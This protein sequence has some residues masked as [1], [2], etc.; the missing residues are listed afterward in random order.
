MVSLSLNT[1][2]P[3][4]QYWDIKKNAGIN[5]FK[6]IL[7]LNSTENVAATAHAQRTENGVIAYPRKTKSAKFYSLLA[8]VSHRKLAPHLA[9]IRLYFYFLG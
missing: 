1:T 4:I 8:L 3:P 6:C 2:V 9:E 7:T 5:T